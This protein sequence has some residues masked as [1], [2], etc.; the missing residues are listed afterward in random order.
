MRLFYILLSVLYIIFIRCTSFLFGNAYRQHEHNAV[1]KY[2][3]ID[4]SIS[5]TFIFAQ[6][7]DIHV[8]FGEQIQWR[9]RRRSLIHV[10]E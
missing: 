2:L 10:P 9:W 8:Q 5:L 1:I 6:Y 3:S 7:S 4:L